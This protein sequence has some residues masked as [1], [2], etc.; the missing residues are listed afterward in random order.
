[1]IC[2][3]RA[4]VISREEPRAKSTLPFRFFHIDGRSATSLFGFAS[5]VFF[6]V[7]V[8]AHIFRN[9]PE[10]LASEFKIGSIFGF[11]PEDLVI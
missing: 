10:F 8:V 6:S 1:M 5:V 11:I 2:R 3:T 7:I 4:R 9:F